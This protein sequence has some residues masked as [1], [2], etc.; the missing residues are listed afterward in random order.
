MDTNT[1]TRLDWSEKTWVH[2]LQSSDDFLLMSAVTDGSLF[3]RRN[4]LRLHCK[5]VV[6]SD[7]QFPCRWRILDVLNCWLSNELLQ[8][9]A[10]ITTEKELTINCFISNLKTIWFSNSSNVMV[11]VTWLRTFDSWKYYSLSWSMNLKK[12]MEEA[13]IHTL[14]TSSNSSSSDFYKNATSRV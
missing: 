2:E 8:K 14:I 6:K 11:G 12:K 13:I 4:V 10:Q 3:S 7:E 5:W 9:V 1:L